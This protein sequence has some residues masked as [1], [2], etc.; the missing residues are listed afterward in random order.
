MRAASSPDKREWLNTACILGVALCVRVWDLRAR[1]LWFDEAGE[2]WIATAPFSQ[3]VA[4]ARTGTGDPP[5]YTLLLHTWMQISDSEA[6]LRFLSVIASVAGVAG[7]M[8]L[9]RRVAGARVAML[10]GVLMAFL[11]SDVR[12]AQEVGQYAFVPAVVAWNLVF[13][14]RMTQ[15]RTWRAVLGW[16]LTALA[17]TY[18]Y[19]ATVF[20]IAACF[21]CVV[22]E[23]IA[24][25]DMRTRRA[26]GTALV[27][28]VVGLIP[29]LVS[30][31]PTQL[32]RVVENSGKFAGAEHGRGVAQILA[33]K[34]KMASELIA[35]QL[36]GWPHSH[37]ATG[38]SVTPVLLLM[39]LAIRRAPRLLIWFAVAINVYA[40][41]D[42]LR[43]FP[44]GY[45]W[46]MIMTPLIICAV[47]VGA[48]APRVRTFRWATLAVY[49]AVV[50]MCVVSL[51]NRWLRDRVYPERSG[52]WPETE[53][54]RVVTNFWME[55]RVPG[56]ATY[57]YYGAAP[58]FAYYTRHLA[59][60]EGIPSTWSFACWHEAEPPA[61]C[62]QNDIYYGRWLRNKSPVEKVQSIV[63]TL[64]DQPD[65]LWLVF[66]HMVPNDD[67]RMIA[68]MIREG[69]RLEA[70]A[71]GVN[72]S[73][74]L[75]VR[76][77]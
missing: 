46:G 65:S 60:R 13:L 56:Q 21:L 55:H 77:R 57:V 28:Y 32:A 68:G 20:P 58:A 67:A 30:Y 54:L 19:Y 18:V 75:L 6:W 50:V 24:R 62:R 16:T 64:G 38:L 42:L 12:Y 27:L 76:N 72:A 2:Y 43:L 59:S 39:V 49:A 74:C 44:L 17:G 9:A 11:P 70:A 69:Y 29:L 47:A 36:T 63:A 48:L 10:A 33:D 7:V 40:A 31:L 4:S 5:L 3:L 22:V 23:S 52:S 26:T 41:V 45:R 61:Y 53:D 8:V 34:W 14:H 25:R 71:Q 73:T 37:I 66:G 15:E 35:F 1:A 51:P